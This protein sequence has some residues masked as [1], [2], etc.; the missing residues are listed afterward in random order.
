LIVRWDWAAYS[1][2]L[3][4]Y[5]FVYCATRRK[6]GTKAADSSDTAVAER[7]ERRLGTE[8]VR[9]EI[10]VNITVTGI[11]LAGIAVFLRI[12][13]QNIGPATVE[14]LSHAT[15]WLGGSAVIGLWNLSSATGLAA[16]RKNVALIWWPTRLLNAAQ[17]YAI[18]LGLLRFVA[19]VAA[20]SQLA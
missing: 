13:V 8:A 14:H 4:Y 5:G 9:A 18:I 12:G 6:R 16:M 7:F 3:F 17:F 19:A 10:T 1:G 11:L 20:L 2:V 15:A